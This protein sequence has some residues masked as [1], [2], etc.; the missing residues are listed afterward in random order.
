M[1]QV[2]AALL[3]ALGLAC[4]G[5]AVAPAPAA[6]ASPAPTVKH[7]ELAYFVGTWR[8]TARNPQTGQSFELDYVAEP[9]LGGAWLAGT[10]EAPALG[11]TI[12]DLWGRDPQ[13]GGIL[14][15]VFD[16]Q[17]TFG[18]VRSPGWSG[19]TLVLEGEAAQGDQ[20]VRVRETIT[21]RDEASF[22][23]VWE[24]ES[25]GTWSAYSV[26]RLVRVR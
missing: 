1:G 20:R 10:G 23:A 2:A 7:P 4:G 25:G 8:A 12:R 3:L 11:L 19:D 14:R 18:T 16:S 5:G 9:V 17:G 24:S 26:E 15:V 13:T 21:R 6:P 22:D